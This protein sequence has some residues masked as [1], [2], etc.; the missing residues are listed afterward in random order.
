MLN[1][2]FELQPVADRLQIINRYRYDQP[3][4]TITHQ[5]PEQLKLMLE[6]PEIS[7]KAQGVESLFRRGILVDPFHSAGLERFRQFFSQVS[8]DVDLYSLSL[9]VMREY[10][11]SEFAV[12]SLVETDLE[13]DLWQPIRSKGEDAPRNYLV[14]YSEPEQLRQLK[15]GMVNV[16]RGDTLFL[17][18]VT[19]GEVSE[20]GPLYVTHPTFCLDCMV[21]R[22]DAYHIRWTTPMI[23]SG[24][25]LLEEEFLK[26]MI[27]HYSSYI[28]LLATVH[29]RKI[30]L[31]NRESS[32]TSLIS[33]RSS[34]CQCQIS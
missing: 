16:E 4:F 27:D 20:I 10:L 12:I 13:L 11:R 17:C 30:L 28:T 32:F 5:R 18:R 31:R 34:R 15:Q 7:A 2:F 8:H 9:V 19:K 26:S 23:M 24:Q 29:E 25:Q 33:P 22:L 6:S 3:L 1:A 14:L 21:S